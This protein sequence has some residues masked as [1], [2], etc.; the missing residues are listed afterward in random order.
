MEVTQRQVGEQLIRQTAWRDPFERCGPD[1]R[2]AAVCR[3]RKTGSPSPIKEERL[4]LD[5]RSQRSDRV[6]FLYP[7]LAPEFPALQFTFGLEP[8]IQIAARLYA[9]FEVN[10]VCASSDFLLGRWISDLS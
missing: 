6:P 7:Q 4:D 2:L 8:V 5:L 1:G 10:F 3:A 9:A